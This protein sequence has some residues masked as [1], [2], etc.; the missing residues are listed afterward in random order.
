MLSLSRP[1]EPVAPRSRAAMHASGAVASKLAPV[2]PLAAAPL[3]H[4]PLWAFLVLA[5]LTV[6]QVL[7]D[8][9]FSVKRSDWKKVRRELAVARA[10]ERRTA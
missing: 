2:V 3:A 5:G 9:T 6:F 1:S 10:Q 8:L 7:T 4:A